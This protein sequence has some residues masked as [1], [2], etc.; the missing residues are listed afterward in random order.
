[1]SQITDE[2]WAFGSSLHVEDPTVGNFYCK[3][4]YTGIT[5][6]KN[7]S[8]WLVGSV[9]AP[10]IHEGWKIKSVMILYNIRGELGLIDKIGIRNGHL[11]VQRFEGL[12]IGPNTTW[13]LRKFELPSAASFAYGLGVTIHVN[14][15]DHPDI[16][17]PT[18]F[19]FTSIGLEFIRST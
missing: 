10:N 3:G 4:L 15:P 6:V 11:D 16:S 17:H 2:R 14:Y 19:L 1:M 12:N 9:P 18:Q 5:L 13:E 7:Q 8:N